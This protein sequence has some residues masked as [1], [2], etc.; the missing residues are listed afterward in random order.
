MYKEIKFENQKGYGFLCTN[1]GTGTRALVGIF[2]TRY[3]ATQVAFN[4][5]VELQTIMPDWKIV[6]WNEKNY[7]SVEHVFNK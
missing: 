6:T 7:N 5:C 1:P 3:E 2:E 4:R